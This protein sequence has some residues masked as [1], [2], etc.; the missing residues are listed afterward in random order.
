MPRLFAEHSLGG[1]VAEREFRLGNF[2][3]SRFS[4]PLLEAAKAFESGRDNFYIHGP[5]GCGKTHIATGIAAENNGRIIRVSSLVRFV[6][7]SITLEG[8]DEDDLIGLFCGRDV[9]EI[10]WYEPAPHCLA[11][12]DLGTEKLTEYAE[13]VIF[14]IIDRRMLE[15]VNG[16]VITSNLRLND[17]IQ[18]LGSERIASRIVKMCKVFDLTG[19]EDYRLKEASDLPASRRGGG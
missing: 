13:S 16:L 15:G 17:L 5:V 4:A 18:R 19:E 8:I 9:S 11:I 14:E 12:D 2:Q 10:G 7:R 1:D 3:A 6:R